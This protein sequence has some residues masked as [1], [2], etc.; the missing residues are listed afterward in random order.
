MRPLSLA[1]FAALAL[2]TP[3]LHA[4]AVFYAVSFGSPSNFGTFDPF[5][6]AFSPVGP[7]LA[8]YVHDIAVSPN[9]TVYAV[10]GTTLV[11]IDKSTGVETTIGTFP[12]AIQTLAFRSD[13]TLFGASYVD[14]YTVDPN[15]AGATVVGYM[16][17]PA[18]ADNIRFGGSGALYVMSAESDSG[19]YTLNQTTAASTLVGQSGVDDTSLG[20]FLGGT[21]YGT[22]IVGGTDNHVV[23]IDP[24]TGLGSEGAITSNTYLFALDPTSVPEPST[25]LAAAGG[26]V[27]LA[28]ARRIRVLLH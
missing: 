6:G 3:A 25:L 21:F 13:G 23:Q 27:L 5:T 9:G 11:T 26:L 12:A 7:G 17:L 18:N 28:V 4:S 14:L 20:A 24:N 15:T 2:G 19:L 8:G 22:N 1:V 16:G 10:D